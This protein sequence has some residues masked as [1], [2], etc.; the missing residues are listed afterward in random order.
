MA[1]IKVDLSTGQKIA[2][3]FKTTRKSTTNPFKYQNFEGNTLQFADVFEGFKPKETNKLK[4]IMSSV[5]GSM[6]KIRS[7]ITEPIS[8]FVERI[9][10]IWEYAKNTNVTTFGSYKPITDVL[11]MDVKDIGNGIKNSIE[12]KI[13]GITDLGKT[14]KAKIVNINDDLTGIGKTIAAPWSALISKI[15]T[16]HIPKDLTVAEYRD[17]WLKENEILAKEVAMDSISKKA[18]VA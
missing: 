9:S 6:T 13:S 7:S 17:L 18:Q 1:K 12:G 3:P 4:L 10:N 2:N 16:H 15:Q 14:L 11:N 8:H 5:A